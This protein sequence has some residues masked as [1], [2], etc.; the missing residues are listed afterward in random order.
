MRRLKYIAVCLF[1]AGCVEPYSPALDPVSLNALVVDGSIDAQGNSTITLS[2][3]VPLTSHANN[4]K[5]SGADVSI[6]SST[7]ET[8]SL[9]EISTGVYTA[10]DLPVNK[11]SSYVLHIR[12]AEG[13]EYESDEVQIHPTPSVGKIYFTVSQTGDDIELRTDSEDLTADATGYYA[14][15]C[16]ETYEYRAQYF[17]RFKRVGDG[18]PELRHPG[19][20]VD[21]C[22][23]EQPI[24][25]TLES[26]K[27]LTQ[28]TISRHKLT[29]INKFSPKISRRYSIL[30]RQRAISEQEYNYRQRLEK[31]IDGQG[32]IFAEIPGAVVSN[33]HS[34]A[35]PG[36]IVL[37]YFRGQ[38]VKEQRFFLARGAIPEEL[39]VELIPEKCDLESTCPVDAPPNGPNTCIDIALLSESKIIITSFEFQ[40]NV[41]Y[42]FSTNECG[43]CRAKG[44]KNVPP[45]YWF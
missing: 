39:Q 34:T 2:R 13:A 21:T 31:S 32:S 23:L 37:G 41:V 22:W 14:W 25:I 1:V 11:Q 35:D 38:E 10:G 28:N 27:R 12:T 44:G 43:D 4:P 45:P 36:E 26:T 30:V 20:F 40:N 42:V 5:E 15:E 33:V 17:S 24:P 9:S 3:A 6:T 8:F 29:T 19:E 16:I 18:F 7:G